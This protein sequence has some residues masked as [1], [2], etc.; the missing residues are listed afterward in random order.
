M[1]RPE[2]GPSSFE[3]CELAVEN[4]VEDEG[5]DEEGVLLMLGER[6]REVKWE[7]TDKRDQSIIKCPLIYTLS[8]VPLHSHGY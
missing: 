7:A 3:K 8:G 5:N 4:I 1:S 2:R 6:E